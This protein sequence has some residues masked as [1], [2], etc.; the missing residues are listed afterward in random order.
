MIGSALV[1]V[2]LLSATASP[3]LAQSRSLDL[4]FSHTGES[5]KVVYKRDGRYVQSAVRDLNRFLRDWRRNEATT[6]DPE[7]FDLLYEIQQ[8]FGGQINIV[9]AYRSPATNSMLRSRSRG[10]AKNSQHMLGKAIDFYIK[11]ANLY[12]LRAAGMRRQVGGVGYY[13]NSGSPFVHMD[14]GSVRA[15]PRMSRSEL[16]KVFPNGKTLHVPSDGKPLAGYAEAQQLEKA[17]KLTSLDRGSGG[18]GGGGLLAMV[19]I[20]R[21]RGGADDDARIVKPVR[22]QQRVTPAPT[23]TAPPPPA[24]QPEVR[25]ASL[26]SSRVS[27]A[28]VPAD[29]G[30][31]RQLPSVSLGG[32]IGRSRNEEPAPAPEVLPVALPTAPLTAV[33]IAD[34]EEGAGDEESAQEAPPAAA[35][36]PPPV[37]RLPP[38]QGT[39]GTPADPSA[40][41]GEDATDPVGQILETAATA[42]IVVAALP[43]QRPVRGGSA[44]DVGIPDAA[45]VPDPA[46]LLAD[47]APV[48]AIPRTEA[49]AY[50]RDEA[51]AALPDPSPQTAVA[52]II[53][54]G[55]LEPPPR[56]RPVGAT[57]FEPT[58]PVTPLGIGQSTLDAMMS[59]VMGASS[60]LIADQSGV[61]SDSFADLVRPDRNTAAADGIL[62]AQGFLGAPAGLQAGTETWP[63][64]DRFTGTRI[65][66]YARPRS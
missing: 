15:W 2:G 8:E 54:R 40:A 48:P 37:P 7:L 64:T 9:S 53:P 50:A 14:T 23:R 5:L 43:P 30:L 11:G 26:G 59:P 58:G 62:L 36:A 41:T 63:T 17:G 60:E 39:P 42:P 49:I 13:P 19:G 6:M 51:G 1:V 33:A 56:P 3:A 52:A 31:F 16:A 18:G 65:T 27:S 25:T 28:E 55:A 44:A 29:R 20:G 21:S 24:A 32:L 38:R 47:A 12:K 46:A 61:A 66:V 4:H 22:V 34:P 35:L 10:V 57:G 45:T